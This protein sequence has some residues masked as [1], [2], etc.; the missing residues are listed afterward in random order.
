MSHKRTAP[1]QW[2]GRQW[3]VTRYGIEALNG[4]YHVPFADVPEAEAG[5]PRWLDDLLR[6]YGT[7]RDDLAAAVTVARAMRPGA[8]AALLKPA[9]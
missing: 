5:R 1:V 9:A 2:Q 7:D 6:R 4:L 8:D 3:A